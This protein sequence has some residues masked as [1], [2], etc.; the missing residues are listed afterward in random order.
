MNPKGKQ[1]FEF[2]KYYSGEK[3]SILLEFQDITVLQKLNI[4]VYR[5]DSYYTVPYR[6]ITFIYRTVPLD[7]FF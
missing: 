3:V 1:T 4:T 5:F 2:V 7:R 6:V